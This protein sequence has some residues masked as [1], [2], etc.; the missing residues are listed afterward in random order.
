MTVTSSPHFQTPEMAAPSKNRK[1]P[2]RTSHAIARPPE[3]A[4]VINLKPGSPT[5]RV[6]ESRARLRLGFHAA[7]VITV[8][9]A[10]FALVRVVMTEAFEKNPRFSLRQVIV[11]TEGALTPQRIVRATGVTEGQ[12]LLTI[13]LREVRE[14]I[15]RM[16]EVRSAVVTR[17]YEGRLAIDVV[18]RR[19]VAWIEC[20]KLRVFHMKSGSGMLLD[21]EG[22]AIPCDVILKDYLKMPVVRIEELAQIVPGAVVGSP[23]VLAALRLIGE[24]EARFDDHHDEIAAVEIPARYALNALFRDGS[25]ATFGSDEMEAQLARYEQ[26]RRAAREKQ[27]EIASMNLLARTN[28][29][30]TFRKSPRLAEAETPAAERVVKKRN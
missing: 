3:D 29:P 22:V 15:E 28:I 6:M 24:F 17:D 30:V 5:I 23:E 9:A 14:R 12:N 10:L 18:Q 8:L 25:R 4:H 1:K 26:I 21:A 11:N 13:N 7:V 27:W 2:H 20:P 19:P 16:P